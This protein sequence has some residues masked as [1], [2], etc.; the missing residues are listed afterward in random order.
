[1]N[2]IHLTDGVV[3]DVM[4]RHP[5][6]VTEDTPLPDVAELLETSAISG[7]P[8]VGANGELVGVIS[9]TDLARVRATDDLWAR[10]PGLAARHL[11]SHPAL[12]V[13]VD[14]PITDAIRRMEADHVHRLV[15]VADD[16][17]TPI[18]VISTTDIVRAMTGRAIHG[19]D[20][21]T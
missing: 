4:S 3:G 6:V 1:M 16:G 21:A 10:W 17:R 7:M 2:Q 8:V 11:M 5:I 14:T 9:G 18:G 12:T 20:A 15:V 19:G 13:S